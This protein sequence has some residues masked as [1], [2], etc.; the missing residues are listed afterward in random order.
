MYVKT[1]LFSSHFLTRIRHLRRVVEMEQKLDGIFALLTASN[2]NPLG[3]DMKLP[4]TPYPTPSAA[5]DP[6]DAVIIPQP[7]N[8]MSNVQ[9]LSLMTPLSS[10]WLKFDEPQDVIGKGIITYNKA[11]ALLRDYGTHAP[12]FPFVV[13]S[14][15][16]SLDSLRHEKPFLLLSILTVASTSNQA[17]QDLLEAELRETL[18]R[19]VIFNGEK[20]LDLLQG[21]LIYLTWFVLYSK[22]QNLITH[23]LYLRYHH[24]F[25]P[26][27]Q[28]IY[29]LSQM[30]IAMAV[31][32]EIS[33]SGSNLSGSFSVSAF[34]DSR[35]GSMRAHRF[36]SELEAMRTFLGC[37]YLSSW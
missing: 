31:D 2:R 7:R 36:P 11:E 23:M 9:P 4:D 27:R 12:N 30:V 5:S 24:F 34:G 8:F 20:S 10:P 21:L 18:G 14:P 25:K 26:E 6:P 37:Y 17:L 15:T 35:T 19:K 13:F 1:H 32:L 16:V 28:Q 33:R 22:Y 29:Q 3:K